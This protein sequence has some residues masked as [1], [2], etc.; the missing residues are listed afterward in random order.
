MFWTTECG[1]PIYSRARQNQLWLR[2][3]FHFVET[4]LVAKLERTWKYLSKPGTWLSVN[5]PFPFA[6][7]SVPRFLRNVA[8]DCLINLQIWKRAL[9]DI[10][11]D[12]VINS[13]SKIVFT[14]SA[15]SA[16]RNCNIQT[17]FGIWREKILFRV[18]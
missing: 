8:S 16:F 1:K 13:P 6:N 10:L 5:F 9:G 14:P 11:G 3:K 12:V 18:C 4:L 2:S 15:N 7:V 17:Y